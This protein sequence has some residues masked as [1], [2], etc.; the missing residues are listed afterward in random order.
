MIRDRLV[1]VVQHIAPTPFAW[2]AIVVGVVVHLAAFFLFRVEVPTELRL[3]DSQPFVSFVALEGESSSSE[4]R[5]RSLLSDSV[6]LFL[7]T[8]VD[9]SWKYLQPN[10]Y[11]DDRNASMMSLIEHPTSLLSHVVIG[12]P[13]ARFPKPN[14]EE[15]LGNPYWDVFRTV[16]EEAKKGL[17]FSK[18]FGALVVLDEATRQ[19]S[20]EKVVLEKPETI[21][22]GTTFWK[23]CEM[24]L[25]VGV[26]GRMG[27]PVVAVS[28]GRLAIDQFAVS[29]CVALADS[30][31]LGS[32]YYRVL[33]T[34]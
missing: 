24:L 18:R 3:P 23:P 4:L 9:Y 21:E 6:P 28:S 25:Y 13:F 31:L 34:P 11:L 14:A 15:L 27:N 32:G 29:E 22:E 30:G 1:A 26:T 8:E 2:I 19:L 10:R 20:H 17:V 12:D 33:F 16:G 7:P 5:D